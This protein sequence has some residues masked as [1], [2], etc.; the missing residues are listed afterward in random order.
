[1]H[2]KICQSSCAT[3]VHREID[4]H[5]F[6]CV[7]ETKFQCFV[8]KILTNETILWCSLSI[9]LTVFVS[10]SFIFC[11]LLFVCTTL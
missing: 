1:M 4:V 7:D 3:Q 5:I 2:A 11:F 8:K 6:L 9:T 10:V